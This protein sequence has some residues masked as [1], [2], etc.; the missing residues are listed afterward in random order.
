MGS[1][2]R[3]REV[4]GIKKRH[5]RRCW[6]EN[7]LTKT[8][9]LAT[10]AVTP[11]VMMCMGQQQPRGGYGGSSLVVRGSPESHPWRPKMAVA[12]GL[13]LLQKCGRNPRK[14]GGD[15]RVDVDNLDFAM[16]HNLN[17]QQL[18]SLVGST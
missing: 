14:M 16:W 5:E 15:D 1:H 11:I 9:P 17:A 7:P 13:K 3:R 4:A 6:Y 8:L 10:S 18:V 12:L 2:P